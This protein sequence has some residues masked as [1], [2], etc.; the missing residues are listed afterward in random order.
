MVAAGVALRGLTDF[1]LGYGIGDLEQ[2]VLWVC[3]ASQV[4]NVGIH[5]IAVG[6]LVD[7]APCAIK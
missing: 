5:E 6:L 3:V 1:T 4:G 2:A 7:L